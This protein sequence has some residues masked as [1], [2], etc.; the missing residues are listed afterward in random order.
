MPNKDDPDLLNAVQ[1]LADAV[2]RERIPGVVEFRQLEDA[3]KEIASEPSDFRWA[4]ADAAFNALDP[5]LRQRV[6]DRAQ[7]LAYKEAKTRR[8]ATPPLSGP[9]QSPATT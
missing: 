4:T 8:H 3:L 7:Q 5:D 1:V 2:R 6:A 9:A